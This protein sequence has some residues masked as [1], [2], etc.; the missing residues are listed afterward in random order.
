MY[1]GLSLYKPLLTIKGDGPIIQWGVLLI[2]N[3]R[4][5]L[6]TSWARLPN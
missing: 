6:F 5:V 2:F 1:T 3:E 4:V